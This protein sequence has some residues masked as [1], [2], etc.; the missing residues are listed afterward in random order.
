MTLFV[1]KLKSLLLIR[2]F[3]SNLDDV[4]RRWLMIMT[5][6]FISFSRTKQWLT[7]SRHLQLTHASSKCSIAL[8]HFE[9]ERRLDVSLRHAKHDCLI[10]R[11]RDWMRMTF[12]YD[13]RWVFIWAKVIL[14]RTNFTFSLEKASNF[15]FDALWTNSVSCWSFITR[16]RFWWEVIWL[17]TTIWLYKTSVIVR[18]EKDEKS[19]EKKWEKVANSEIFDI[20]RSYLIF[21]Y[22]IQ[23]TIHNSQYWNTSSVEIIL[24]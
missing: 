6:S 22:I 10:V 13:E 8:R 20:V 24:M 12:K 2:S 9:N 17:L 15:R 3:S 23:F 11:S 16:M 4:K 14:S 1:E 18:C 5:L 21:H 19:K 7:W